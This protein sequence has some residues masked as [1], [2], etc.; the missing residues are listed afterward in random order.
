MSS[1]ISSMSGLPANLTLANF[2]AAWEAVLTGM[3]NAPS[4]ETKRLTFYAQI[5][6]NPD[7]SYDIARYNRM[8]ISDPEKTYDHLMESCI[9]LIN[10][11]RQE[12]N[13]TALEAKLGGG[14]IRTSAPAETRVKKK[15]LCKKFIAGTCR[16][17]GKDCEYS[18]KSE[19]TDQT[20]KGDN[21]KTTASPKTDKTK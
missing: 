2:L 18:H 17:S 15:E 6:N 14:N 20:A 10:R 4:E 11:K 21:A 13:I 16:K 3:N 12:D 8:R 5:K 19:K 9:T 1:R 7:L